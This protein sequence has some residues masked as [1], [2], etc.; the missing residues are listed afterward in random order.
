MPS[1]KTVQ[2]NSINKHQNLSYAQ[3]KCRRT[4]KEEIEAFKANIAAT[5]NQFIKIITTVLWEI[6]GED[7]GCKD[8]LG[9]RVSGIVR[10]SLNN[11]TV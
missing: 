11:S 3:A 2:A 1:F 6:T 4:T 9:G 10:Q 8:H 5:V 7:F